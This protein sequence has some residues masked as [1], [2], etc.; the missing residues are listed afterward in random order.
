[1]GYT[2]GKIFLI[3]NPKYLRKIFL[4]SKFFY[5]WIRVQVEQFEEKKFEVKNVWYHPLNCRYGSCVNLH[6]NKY[7]LFKRICNKTGFKEK[8]WMNVL[9]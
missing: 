5:S 4:Y 7:R 8:T 2:T 3:F 6:W 1:V 9:C